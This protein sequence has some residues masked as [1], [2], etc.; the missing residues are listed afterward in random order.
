MHIFGKLISLLNIAL[1]SCSTLYIHIFVRVICTVSKSGQD[2]A[3]LENAQNA[4]T[5]GFKRING[6]HTHSLY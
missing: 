2:V 3:N 5:G 4:A 6:G 1:K